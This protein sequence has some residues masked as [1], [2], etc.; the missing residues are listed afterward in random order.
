MTTIAQGSAG[1]RKGTA[2]ETDFPFPLKNSVPVPGVEINWY[3]SLADHFASM[4]EKAQVRQ[5]ILPRVA[6]CSGGFGW[7]VLGMTHDAVIA[8]FL[9][10]APSLARQFRK[11]EEEEEDEEEGEEKKQSGR[12]SRRQRKRERGEGDREEYCSFCEKNAAG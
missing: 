3:L 10:C 12:R 8:I 6:R 9:R 2:A 11:V 1:A 5:G 7:G 4:L